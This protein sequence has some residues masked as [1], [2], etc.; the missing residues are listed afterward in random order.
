M[1]QALLWFQAASTFVVGILTLL[2]LIK[3][4]KSAERIGQRSNELIERHKKWE[5]LMAFNE[6]WDRLHQLRQDLEPKGGQ[7]QIE[8]FYKRYWEFQHNQYIAWKN[9]H[10]DDGIFK[11]WMD[12]RQDDWKTEKPL[13]EISFQQAWKDEQKRKRFEDSGFTEF[14]ETVFNRGAKQAI[15]DAKRGR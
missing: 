13:G 2:V 5:T 10:V 11:A 15:D 9:G 3:T 6:T 8:V 4:I 14:M 7:R 1:D 12:Q